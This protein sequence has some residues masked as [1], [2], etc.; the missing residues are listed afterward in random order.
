VLIPH[1]LTIENGELTPKMNIRRST[2]ETQYSD[3]I[4][5]FYDES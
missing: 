2:L 4:D 5:A 1:Q 3:K